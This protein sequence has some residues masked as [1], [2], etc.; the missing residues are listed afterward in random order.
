VLKYDTAW[1][2]YRRLQTWKDITAKIPVP[3][4]MD[5]QPPK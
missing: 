1:N 4:V 5:D 3:I 2:D